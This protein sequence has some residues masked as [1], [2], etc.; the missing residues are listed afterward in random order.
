MAQTFGA[1]VSLTDNRMPMQFARAVVGKKDIILHTE[2]KSISNFVYLTDAVTGILKVL[3][4]GDKG[5]AYNVCNDKE[6]K[7]VREIAELVCED[8]ADGKISVRVE[9]KKT[10][11]MRLT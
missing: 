11:D 3:V 7:S 1:G 2:G 8:V 4:E 9:E 6:S 5:Q 10:W